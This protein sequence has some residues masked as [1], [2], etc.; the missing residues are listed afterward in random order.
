MVRLPDAPEYAMR[1]A[2]LLIAGLVCLSLSAAAVTAQDAPRRGRADPAGR[3][4]VDFR[5]RAGGILGHTF[6]VY[7]RTDG[8]GRVLEQHYAGLYPDDAYDT[9][10]LLSV[11]L[12]PGY[13][14]LKREDPSKPVTATYRRRLNAAEYAHLRT[15]VRRLKSTQR[16]WH[17]AF[18]N[19]NDF[20][21]QVAREMGM[22]APHPWALPGAFVSTLRA[23]NGP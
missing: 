2:P 23:I 3:Y 18:Y 1:S 14:T 13:V 15:T 12:V 21:A 7:G 11:A 19:C 10:P 16:Q 6:I 9:S 17:M 4:F 20:A 5:A 8:R 22:I